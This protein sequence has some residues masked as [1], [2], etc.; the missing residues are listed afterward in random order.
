MVERKSYP[1]GVPCWVDIAHADVQAAVTFYTGLFDWQISDATPHGSP[2]RYYVARCGVSAVAGI[3]PLATSAPGASGKWSTY[4]SVDDADAVVGRVRDAGGQ[5]LTP[6]IDAPSACRV[7]VCADPAGA[8]FG[9]WQA[10]GFGGAELVNAPGSWNWSDLNAS[11]LAAARAFY[12]TVFGWET[13]PV[14]FGSAES[15]MVRRP[16]YSDFLEQIDPGVRARHLDAGAPEGFTDAIAWMRPLSSSERDP[17][18]GVTFSVDDTD[19]RAE[20]VARLGGAVL[21]EPFDVPY[22]RMAVVRDPQGAV[23]S[24]SKFVPPSKN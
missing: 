21:V 12:A 4:I 9:V 19:A 16:G 6:P 23:F 18:W 1:A 20:R 13:T 5:V 14:D 24:I 11:D 17:H 2:G 15:F 22:S 7:A 10:R 8:V 3:A